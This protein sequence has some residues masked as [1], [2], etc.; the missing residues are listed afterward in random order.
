[1]QKCYKDSK[2]KGRNIADIGKENGEQKTQEKKRSRELATQGYYWLIIIIIIRR[3]HPSRKYVVFGE[4]LNK[5]KK[6]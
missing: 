5:N 4:V 6:Y 1:M 2:C 3:K